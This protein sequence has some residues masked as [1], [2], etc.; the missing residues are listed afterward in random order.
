MSKLV[1]RELS[2]LA[3]LAVSTS[4]AFAGP[5]DPTP[6]PPPPH[7]QQPQGLT[8]SVPTRLKLNLLAAGPTDPTPPPPPPHISQPQGSNDP[9]PRAI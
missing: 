2:V 4:P 7:I 6:P 9:A 8:D 1:L 5:T 3:A